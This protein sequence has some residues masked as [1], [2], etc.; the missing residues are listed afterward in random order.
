MNARTGHTGRA[1]QSREQIVACAGRAEE[2]HVMQSTPAASAVIADRGSEFLWLLVVKIVATTLEAAE[3]GALHQPRE[4]LALSNGDEH[5]SITPEHQNRRKLR[6]MVRTLEE[7][8]ALT[9]PIDDV[10]NRPGE[11]AGRPGS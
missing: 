10:P 6:E 7:G 1:F 9:S 4:L 8:A 5:V 11:R 2:V 3:D